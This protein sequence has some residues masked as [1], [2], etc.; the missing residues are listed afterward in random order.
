MIRARPKVVIRE[1]SPNHYAGGIDPEIIA[2][3]DTESE[4]LSGVVSWFADPASQVSAHVVTDKTGHSARCVRDVDAAWHVEAFNG[5][6]LGIEQTGYASF[7]VS[8]WL[9]RRRELH[10]TSRWIAYWS[11][12]HGIPI[13]AAVVDTKSANVISPGVTMHKLLGAAG[14][15]HHDPGAYP[16]KR[17]LRWAR[18]Y[19]RFL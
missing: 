11:K 7:G 10:E 8:G 1:L 17:V 6:A 4:S 15:G 5:V 12:R 9:G 16:F 18:F 13:R 2:I 19:R 3:H 14:G